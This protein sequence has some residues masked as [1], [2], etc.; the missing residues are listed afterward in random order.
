MLGAAVLAR[1]DAA[2]REKKTHDKS[3]DHNDQNTTSWSAGP[4]PACLYQ[5]M[6][7]MTTRLA[8]HPLLF[9]PSRP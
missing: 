6:L 3:L 4:V 5:H 8:P 9:I 2:P 7:A 1:C